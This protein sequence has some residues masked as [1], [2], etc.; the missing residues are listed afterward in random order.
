MAA[1]AHNPHQGS[2]LRVTTA[3]EQVVGFGRSAGT[4]TRY[5]C[6]VHE[7]DG[8]PHRPSLSVKYLA[9]AG[10]TKV[11]CQA[12]CDDEQ[13]LDAIGLTVRDLYDNPI[14]R[15]TG[16]ARPAQRPSF[17]QES[18][19]D[20][21]LRAAGI[22]AKKAKRGLGEQ[23]SP[24]K[25][26]DTYTYVRAD[27]TVA[28]EVI[29]K[30]ADFEGGRDKA[31]SQRAWNPA[32]NDWEHTGFDKIPFRLPEV[33]AAIEAGRTIYLV[34]G[35]KDALTAAN[36]GLVAT[37]N[38]GGA[39]A[40]SPEHAE[41]LR[42]ART[43]VIVADVDAPG[44]HRADRVM[45][46]LSG[47]VGRVRVVRA[48]TGKDLTDHLAAGHRV[49]DLVPIPHLD[50][51][52]RALA[53]APDPSGQTA[54]GPA[55]PPETAPPDFEPPPDPEILSAAPAPEGDLTMP[56]SLLNHFDSPSAGHSD[57]V[58]HMHSQWSTF[59][60][61][62]MQ[63]MLKMATKIIEQRAA[64]ERHRATEEHKARIA[65][66]ERLAAEQAAV[67]A[68][69]RKLRS[70]GYDNASRTELAF[71]LADAATW[72]GSSDVAESEMGHLTGHI[73]RRFG[74]AIDTSTGEVGI[75]GDATLAD[76]LAAEQARAEAAR[77]RK[78]QDHM[79][80]LV[81]AEA[82]LDESAKTELY[83]AIESWRTDPSAAQ[84]SEL[85]RKL[86]D[87][88]ASEQTRTQV[89]FVAAYLGAPAVIGDEELATATTVTAAEELGR[90]PRPLVD[91]G[92][93]AK[94]R[95]DRLLETYQEQ[96]RVGAP[97]KEVREELAREVAVLTP[98]DQ[99][100]ARARGKAIRANPAGMYPRMWPAHV[101]RDELGAHIHAYAQLAPQ[102][103]R[104]AVEADNF[105]D[106]TATE[107]RKQVAGHRNAIK[108]ALTNGE[109]LHQLEKDQIK[110][111]L[112]DIDAGKTQLP[113]QLFADDR[114]VAVVDIARSERIA[115]TTA[116]NQRRDLEQI[117][118]SGGVSEDVRVKVS[119]HLDRTTG[120]VEAA[121]RQGADTSRKWA[122]RREAVV[123]AR[124]AEAVDYD[125][126]QRL[127]K[128][129]AKLRAADLDEDQI[130]ERIAADSS[131]AKPP[132]AA[133]EAPKRTRT[134]NPGDGMRYGHN[135]NGKGRGQSDPD[136]SR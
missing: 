28:G 47:L 90:T 86:R 17:R 121:H 104:A 70:A 26:T 116:R 71:A 46:T 88:K 74:L 81:A 2:W 136:Q 84:L 118:E 3:L 68:R 108:E 87:K 51:Y 95:I 50:P 131:F 18:R 91:P 48:A 124:A 53:A 93:E 119:D 13:V 73:N 89:R 60:R 120:A 123:I 41:H 15:G 72:A 27:G 59:S 56:E 31:F 134:T 61:L 38:A 125:S 21:A 112:R 115:Y 132:S 58:D 9:D 16:Q 133:A 83:A 122:Q 127:Q 107:L 40:W 57:E 42:G 22:P 62:L 10:R 100:A 79:V 32:R 85:T 65:D 37:T 23:L 54:P 105:T 69:L 67:E 43:V 111:V 117:L 55:P 35:E 24:W 113:E 4:W 34:E 94:P 78:T 45:D 30:E 5:C 63:Q 1:P 128:L 14:Q 36:A 96:L 11:K 102:A 39:S 92:E 6:P 114:S 19:S 66:E 12:G 25:S 80:S 103:E 8:R 20:R 106:A 130:A 33:R 126:P 76:L 29:R 101:D 75:D 77:T 109:G 52:T 64:A 135:R 82:D 7:G 97:T 49:A 98:D 99:D 44:Y 110:A 129:A